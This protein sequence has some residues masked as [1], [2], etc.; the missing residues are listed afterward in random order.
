MIPQAL[1]TYNLRSLNSSRPNS[2]STSD[3]DIAPGK[4]CLFAIIKNGA[5]W[6]VSA[7]SNV[8][9]SDFA[10]VLRF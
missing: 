6:S 4:S 9:S 3:D 2:S 7:F 1:W 5:S 8:L 10:S